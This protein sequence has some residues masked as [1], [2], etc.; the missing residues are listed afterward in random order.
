MSTPVTSDPTVASSARWFWWIAGLSL[1]NLLLF[2][3][4]SNTNF[5]VGLGMTAVVS[6]V[7]TDPKVVG[8]ILSALI[9]GHYG[10]I[11]YFALREKLWA[12]Y[13]GLVVY[14]I[15]ALVYAFFEDWMPVAFH[16]YVIFHLF[17][18]ISA[19]RGRGDEAPAP[20]PMEQPQSP[21]AGA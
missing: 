6:A 9:I 12:F 13:I 5:V 10:V 18:G 15:D 8:L 1:V 17:K 7:F 16:A 14:V 19:L 4:G 2:Y 11:G 21:E 3:A 20:A